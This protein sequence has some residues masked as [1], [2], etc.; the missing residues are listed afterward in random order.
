MNRT[1]SV[2]HSHVLLVFF[3][4]VLSQIC[5]F[6]CVLFQAQRWIAPSSL[7]YV[8]TVF[9]AGTVAVRNNLIPTIVASWY[10]WPLVN[11]VNFRY[12]PPQYRY[13]IFFISSIANI[14]AI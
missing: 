11:F 1:V 14:T 10:C 6:W 7:P 4:C 9:E 5:S 12:V 8:R 3:L 2:E 13:S